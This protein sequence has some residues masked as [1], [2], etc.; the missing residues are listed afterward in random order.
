[1]TWWHYGSRQPQAWFYVVGWWIGQGL[2]LLWKA[3]NSIPK[4]VCL[5]GI[6]LTLV[7]PSWT[8]FATR[9]FTVWHDLVKVS[10]D[11]LVFGFVVVGGLTMSYHSFERPKIS[12]LNI[13]LSWMKFCWYFHH[14]LTENMSIPSQQLIFVYCVFNQGLTLFSKAKNIIPNHI[15]LC[16]MKFY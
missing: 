16:G 9:F 3:K 2:P 6:K 8:D 7:F 5:C 1:M 11:N 12:F 15:C 13:Y 14:K 10:L 4:H